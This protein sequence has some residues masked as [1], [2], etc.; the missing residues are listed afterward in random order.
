MTKH[1]LGFKEMYEVHCIHVFEGNTE[2]ML[3]M[4]NT[5]QTENCPWESFTT[6]DAISPVETR[7]ALSTEDVSVLVVVKFEDFLSVLP[8]LLPVTIVLPTTA[9]P[10]CTSAQA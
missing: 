9:Q 8:L 7:P 2:L 5:V 4:Y 1:K 3:E 6:G 10:F